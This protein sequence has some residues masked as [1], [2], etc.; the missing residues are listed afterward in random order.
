VQ[1]TWL[2]TPVRMRYLVSTCQNHAEPI[3]FR[4]VQFYVIKLLK[5]KP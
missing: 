2:V 1:L 3:G 5:I 4:A